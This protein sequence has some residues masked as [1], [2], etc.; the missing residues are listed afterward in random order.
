MARTLRRAGR[1]ESASHRARTDK[2]GLALAMALACAF[3]GFAACGAFAPALM[4]T[5]LRPG[6]SVT[7]AFAFGLAV[8]AMG[9]V[10]TAV[11]VAFANREGE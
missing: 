4:R 11:Y 10:F 3:F 5:P 7:A 9:V 8:I 1:T 6:G 2:L